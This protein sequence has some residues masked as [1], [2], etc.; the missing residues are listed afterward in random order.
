MLRTNAVEWRQPR[1]GSL[2]LRCSIL[3]V[4]IVLG[5]LVVHAEAFQVPEQKARQQKEEPKPPLPRFNDL[6]LPP[7][8]D[9]DQLFQGLDGV[10][11]EQLKLLQQQVDRLN[12]E[13]RK[14]M[15]QGGAQNR[16]GGAGLLQG[17]N[18]RPGR[19]NRIPA[20]AEPNSRLG[21]RVSRPTDALVDQ[22]DLPTGQGLVIEELTTDSAAARAGVKANDILLELNGKPV[23][24]NPE[25]FN[26]QLAEIKP[27]EPVEAMVL[28][29]ARKEMIKGLSLPEG[30][31]EQPQRGLQFQL[32]N[33]NPP[34]GGANGQRRSSITTTRTN[35]HFTSRQQ[36]GDEVIT[37]S[38]RVADGK[39]IIEEVVVQQRGTLTRYETLDKVPEAQRA[40]A[41]NMADSVVSRSERRNR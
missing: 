9:F 16:F 3:A 25:E 41:Q 32:P 29:K 5:G 12:Q 14:S 13:L 19:M 2:A 36:Q 24:S 38:G 1:Q 7:G 6:N 28:R 8:L 26:R 22:L 20:T 21:A 10:D 33:L 27:N 18:L 11:Q 31:A 15:Q 37:V 39:P 35:D 30:R 23:S 40:T 4:A 34:A 17:L